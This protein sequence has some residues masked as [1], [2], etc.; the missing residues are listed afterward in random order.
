MTSTPSYKSS[1]VLLDELGIVEPRDIKIEAIA[2]YCGA[3]I[4]YEPLEG[5][6]ARILGH[7]DRAIITVNS[8]SLRQRQR[9]SGAHELGHW[10]RDRGKIA[11]ACEERVFAAEWGNE[12]AEWRANRY[13]VE[14]LLPTFMFAPRAK[15]RD[16]IFATVRDLA[17]EFETSLTATAIRLIELGSYPAMLVCYEEGKR[18]WF[19]RGPDVPQVLW[20]RMEPVSYTSAYDLIH[21]KKTAEGPTDVCADGWFETRDAERYE[22]R[23]DSIKILDRFVLSL[24]WWKDERQI[25]DLT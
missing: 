1:S 4:V 12:T 24:L 9:F 23:E 3:T 13:A 10:M 11:F 16:I 14:L 8:T 19:S 18:R 20:P 5:C 7:N 17:M 25:L 22:L 2:E 6:E 15:S 21:G